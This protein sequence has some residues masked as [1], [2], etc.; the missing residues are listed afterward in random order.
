[1][2]N[3]H[4]R[5]PKRD[6]EGV[7][8]GSVL[9]VA[10]TFAIVGVDAVPVDA[11]VDINRGLPSFSVVGLPD[12]AVRESR[13]RVRAAIVNSGFE[14][15]LRRITVSLAP[16]DLRKAGP[17]FD[18]AIA[19]AILV[20]SGQL[21][22]SLLGDWAF[23]GELA[24]DGRL[25]SVR[26]VLAMAD[27]AGPDGRRGIAVPEA[28]HADAAL[29]EGLA[30][31]PLDSLSALAA[32][33][34]GQVPEARSN[35]A[36]ARQSAGKEAALPDLAELRG[37]P[38]LRR[39]LEIA[40][41]GG[42][43]LLVVGPPGSGKS[44]AAR[45]LPSI[46]PPLSGSEA[47]E[48]AR[49]AG[50]AG[51][52]RP[53]RSRLVRPFRAPHHTISPAGLVGGGT[54]PR[55]GEISLA[56]RGVLFL[57][58]IAEFP[59]AALEALRQPLESGE[60]TIARARGALK[61]PARF[62]LIA[63]ANPCPCGRGESDPRCSCSPE[64]VR[65][66]ASRV[67]GALS[68]RIDITLSLGQPDAEALAGDRPEGSAAVRRRVLAVRERQ[69][70]RLGDARTNA[71]CDGDE[72]RRTA[73]LGRGGLQAL[74]LAQRRYALSG[75]GWARTLRVARTFADAGAS[76]TVGEQHVLAALALRDRPE[77][78]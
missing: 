61:F 16:S 2:P 33:G 60:V 67:S 56:H 1:L 27:A 77:A 63:A 58:E 50:V 73:A 19:A 49:I 69:A 64:Q 71:D 25:R 11:E 3:R 15:P 39:G 7:S 5:P 10:R 24:L 28:D 36:D 21:P 72:L 30:V 26:G 14:F 37:Q 41:A 54:P 22:A 78:G 46:L 34:R 20:A 62:Q 75:R 40:A 18:L 6:P 44:L 52:T 51:A 38:A 45:R 43:S 76:D 57:D 29:I 23:A 4:G 47:I 55:P 9:A 48:V 74:R 31:A 12:A 13:E 70:A 42:H 8:V 35:G 66:Y 32:L 59:R 65:R 53:P 17:G 68:D